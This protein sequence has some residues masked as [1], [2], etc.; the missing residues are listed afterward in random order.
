M[1][2]MARGL[3][4]HRWRVGTLLVLLALV[5][6]LDTSASGARSAQPLGA[7]SSTW[8][9]LGS[10]GPE[11][12][13]SL[14]PSPSWPRG[15][16]FAVQQVPGADPR[17][18]HAAVS[19]V[20]GGRSWEPIRLQNQE[21]IPRS[22][23]LVAAGPG[24]AAVAFLSAPDREGVAVLHRS[25]DATRWDPVLE[26]AGLPTISPNFATDGM[27]LL[28]ATTGLYRSVDA[29]ATWELVLPGP[30]K[31]IY[32]S[33]SYAI[34]GLLLAHSH[35]SLHRSV[36]AGASWQLVLDGGLA[37]HAFAPVFSPDFLER[38]IV[39]IP[40]RGF[41]VR[42]RD[43]GATWEEQPGIPEGAWGVR[44]SPA[45]ARDGTVFLAA[46]LAP[47]LGRGSE[48]GT[49]PDLP[50]DVGLWIS[51]D[52]G[53]SWGPTADGLEIDGETY[54]NIRALA[55]SPNYEE[56]G[57]VFAVGMGPRNRPCGIGPGRSA[58]LFLSR[59][60]GRRWA[61]GLA[62][63]GSCTPQATIEFSRGHHDDGIALLSYANASSSAA[64]GCSVAVT[65]DWGA[66]W[67]SASY[68]AF[69]GSCQRLLLEFRGKVVVVIL[70]RFIRGENLYLSLDAG[71]SWEGL[72]PPS[73]SS[74]I[75][76][77]LAPSPFFADDATLVVGT[78]SGE[79]WAVQLDL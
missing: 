59:D 15:F 69:L 50:G 51:T 33:P 39:I 30:I 46:G 11:P 65:S 34:D 35:R 8:T 28:A 1:Q 49:T 45:F 58:A 78:S 62:G 12:I 40:A 48:S 72:T 29:G 44:F 55:V 71:E 47:S 10:P 38:G 24:S 9:F 54:M 20:D 16:L 21:A 19:S 61:L 57:A 31:E 63:L 41:L 37:V 77:A 42:S 36:D 56:D 18:P 43:W 2:S 66:N 5:G 4:A 67:R 52:A 22:S 27:V 6:L 68:S 13:V 64:Q 32:F 60:Q 70:A 14:I 25:T 7:P 79:V 26:A 74:G 75:V 3:V 17:V 73:D 76:T 53:E 23:P